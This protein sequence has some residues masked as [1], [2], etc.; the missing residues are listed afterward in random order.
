MDKLL[1]QKIDAFLQEN[2]D[3]IVNDLIKMSRI[4]AVRGEA[5]EGAPFGK[6]VARSLEVCAQVARDMG[7]ETTLY[8]DSGYAVT[9]FGEG[10]KSIGFFGH[11]DVVPAGDG[12][13][14]CE[15]FEPTVIDGMR[16]CVRVYS[17][18]LS[19]SNVSA[20]DNVWLL[21]DA[22]AKYILQCDCANACM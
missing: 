4:P 12:W 7:F 6:D 15:P 19:Q 10:E 14:M 9:T 20:Y 5:E 21:R 3:N 18:G 2:R 22:S 13:T 16:A 17:T 1:E 8:S 11:A